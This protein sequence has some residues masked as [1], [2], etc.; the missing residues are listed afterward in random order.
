R[1]RRDTVRGCLLAGKCGD[2]PAT[3]RLGEAIRNRQR[4]PVAGIR[5]ARVRGA[6]VLPGT[7]IRFA[8]NGPW[9][10]IITPLLEKGGELPACLSTQL[11]AEP[12]AGKGPISNDGV[13]R[14]AEGL[15]CFVDIQTAEE[16]HFEDAPLTFVDFCEAPQSKVHS[17]D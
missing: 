3:I 10:R 7:N 4:M 15:C 8:S 14:D 11:G 12:C 1:K 2:S 13:W 6:A 17:H 16:T 9:P 5:H